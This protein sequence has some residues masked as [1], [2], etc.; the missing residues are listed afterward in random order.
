M[1]WNLGGH[2]RPRSFLE[3]WPLGNFL[4]CGRQSHPCL[5]LRSYGLLDRG[6]ESLYLAAP[7]LGDRGA[8]ESLNCFE[9]SFGLSPDLDQ[10][11]SH[12][13]PQNPWAEIMTTLHMSSDTSIDAVLI[14]ST[15]LTSNLPFTAIEACIAH[16]ISANEHVVT[17]LEEVGI[18]PEQYVDENEQHPRKDES[19]PKLRF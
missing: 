15:K 3:T 18:A 6:V 14:R 17:T 9:Q 13:K 10:T 7:C 12:F 16:V 2:T 19:G 8:F 4:R 11:E 1:F 5:R